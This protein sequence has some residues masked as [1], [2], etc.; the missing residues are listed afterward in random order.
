[1]VAEHIKEIGP[2]PQEGH[3]YPQAG[4]R[5]PVH[6]SQ[7]RHPFTWVTRAVQRLGGTELYRKRVNALANDY[8]AYYDLSNDTKILRAIDVL[9]LPVAQVDFYYLPNVHWDH[10]FPS[11]LR[12]IAHLIDR[13]LL[14]PRPRRSYNYHF[15]ARSER[16]S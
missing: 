2:F 4:R 15:S 7:C 8:P 12:W 16:R 6:V 5:V 3:R 11:K 13:T 14:L 10:Y 1:M 9:R